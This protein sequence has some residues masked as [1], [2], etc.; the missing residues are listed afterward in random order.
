MLAS[1]TTA[2]LVISSYALACVRV[3]R[4]QAS[5]WRKAGKY[6]QNVLHNHVSSYSG[7]LLT[8]GVSD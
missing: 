4:T 3:Y 1:F 2:A 8:N 6:R 7:Y 5:D